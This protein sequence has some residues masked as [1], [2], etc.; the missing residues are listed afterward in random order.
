MIHPNSAL[1]FVCKVPP[2]EPRILRNITTHAWQSIEKCPDNDGTLSKR[3]KYLAISGK[4]STYMD[5]VSK[6]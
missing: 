6:M 4:R 5:P 2:P 3:L 1:F